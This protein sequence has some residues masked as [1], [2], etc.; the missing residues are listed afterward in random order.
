MQ[1]SGDRLEISYIPL[2]ESVLCR[3]LAICMKV[4]E[5][6]IVNYMLVWFNSC[7]PL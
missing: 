3:C 4:M 1:S 7:C 6:K 2:T 5:Y